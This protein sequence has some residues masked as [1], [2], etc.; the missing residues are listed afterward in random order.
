[1]R[2]ACFCSV[3]AALGPLRL[4]KVE[5]REEKECMRTHY[6]LTA[7]LMILLA[8][9]VGVAMRSL[10]VPFGPVGVTHACHH[11]LDVPEGYI[12]KVK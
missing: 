12:H 8:R 2:C 7:V 4:I 11:N 6:A 1:M 3:D 5:G 9:L 10:S